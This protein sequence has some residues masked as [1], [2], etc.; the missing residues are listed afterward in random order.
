VLFHIYIHLN[1]YSVI[2]STLISYLMW[3]QAYNNW[4]FIYQC[5]QW[6]LSL[7]FE[8]FTS[9][10]LKQPC[11]RVSSLI[12]TILLGEIKG[13]MS[14]LLTI[15]LGEIKGQMSKLL[16]TEYHLILISKYKKKVKNSC[17]TYI[18]YPLKTF[19]LLTDLLQ[20]KTCST[21]EVLL[22]Y[23]SYCKNL[24]FWRI[25]VVLT[26]NTPILEIFASCHMIQVWVIK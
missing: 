13:Q 17:C 25:V 5:N 20:E 24:S 18:Q 23:V 26:F 8:S 12:L 1:Q 4:I 22:L 16:I 2:K 19:I 10:Y 7:R 9:T 15:S 6:L 11:V 14:K 3:T 21:F